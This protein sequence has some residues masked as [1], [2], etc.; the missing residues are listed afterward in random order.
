MK[1]TSH[2]TNKMKA[3]AFSMFVKKAELKKAKKERKNNE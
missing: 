2:K 1:K 3:N